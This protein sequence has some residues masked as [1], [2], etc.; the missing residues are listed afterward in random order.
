M[1]YD[2]EQA[3][4]LSD[5]EIKRLQNIRRNQERLKSI[6]LPTLP[7]TATKKRRKSE[8]EKG[9]RQPHEKRPRS[10][11]LQAKTVVNNNKEPTNWD[12]RKVAVS[13]ESCL[14]ITLAHVLTQV[15]KFHPDNNDGGKWG[16][17]SWQSAS[18]MV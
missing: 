4:Q 18:W 12:G 16:R 7:P 8:I 5:Y 1:G 2:E 13:T 10:S 3:H 6:G 15:E 9:G 17:F 11:R 14:T